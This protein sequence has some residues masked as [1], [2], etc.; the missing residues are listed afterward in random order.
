MQAYASCT[1]CSTSTS[2][3]GAIHT[4]KLRIHPSNAYSPPRKCQPS[5][6]KDEYV[7]HPLP[8]GMTIRLSNK[9]LRQA[10]AK[11]CHCLASEGLFWG[12]ELL[13]RNTVWLWKV[14]CPAQVYYH[15][16]A[17][18]SNLKNSRSHFKFRSASL[19]NSHA[20]Y[21][22]AHMQCGDHRLHYLIHSRS[23]L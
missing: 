23:I 17:A 20:H 18:I 5:D 16:I 15:T 13:L 11:S 21:F 12:S 1:I 8:I 4:F 2:V 19:G 10:Y 6:P 9:P 7:C 3:L 14:P 22:L